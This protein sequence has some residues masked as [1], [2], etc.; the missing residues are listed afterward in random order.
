MR[1]RDES[2]ASKE[3]H[4]VS[5]SHMTRS[6]ERARRGRRSSIRALS[7]IIILIARVAL[8]NSEVFYSGGKGKGKVGRALPLICY[9]VA[10]RYRPPGSRRFSDE[11]ARLREARY[12][13]TRMRRSARE[14]SSEVEKLIKAKWRKCLQES[15]R[16]GNPA[17]NL[18][19]T[20]TRFSLALRLIRWRDLI[21]LAPCRT[22]FRK[23]LA[24]YLS[25]PLS[26]AQCELQD[27]C[28]LCSSNKIITFLIHAP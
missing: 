11:A 13:P 28:Y 4:Q 20:R 16:K 12:P 1:E 22:R 27:S 6:H 14:Q 23:S 5:S 18:S 2:T 17:M 8:T 26:L 19:F 9:L 21:S 25:S 10:L 3:T 24:R 7:R 15:R